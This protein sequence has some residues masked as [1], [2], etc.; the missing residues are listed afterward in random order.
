MQVAEI[1]PGGCEVGREPQRGLVVPRRQMEMAA[2][3][4][5]VTELGVQAGYHFAGRTG[6]APAGSIAPSLSGGFVDPAGRGLVL[7]ALDMLGCRRR[8]GLGGL[9]GYACG[10]GRT[11][12][13]NRLPW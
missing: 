1:A 10:H 6:G 4:M 3:N 13:T 5:A 12:G 8:D 2:P 7:P 9:D 11:L